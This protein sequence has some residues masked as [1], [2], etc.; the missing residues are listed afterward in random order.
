MPVNNLIQ[1]RR[2]GFSTWSSQDTILASGEPG[3]DLTNNILKIG[4][5]VTSWLNLLST[6]SADIYTYVKNTTG[7]AL[8]KGQV[9]YI[10]GAQG[11]NPTIQ[12]S[13]ASNEAGSS[14]TLGLLKQNLADNEFGY[15][16]SEGILE[17]IDTDSASA[18]GDSMWLSPNVSGGIVYGLANKPSAPNHM[19]FLGYVLRKQSNNGKIY[20][21]VQNG[22]ELEELHNVAI[23]G[24]S[25]GQFLQYNSGSG[26]WVGSSSGNFTTLSINGTPV[27]IS[28]HSHVSTDISDWNEAVDN[29]VSSLLVGTSGINISYNDSSNT[30]SIAYTGSTGGGGG[31]TNVNN[32]TDNRIITSDG[33]STGLNAESNLTF[34]GSKITI[35][36][37]IDNT[38]NLYSS[39]SGIILGNK[40][41]I[42]QS[43]QIV[44][45]QGNFSNDGDAQ[46]S[47][48]LLKNSTNS[49]NWTP[50]LLNNTNAILLKDNSTYS[51]DIYC[52]GRSIITSNN[53]AFK[54]QGLLYNDASG[55]AIV[56]TPIKTIFE[57]TEP[58]WDVRVLI[59]GTGYGTP[60]YLLTQV[61]G[62]TSDIYWVAKA[63]ML[64][65]QAAI[66]IPASPTTTS[67]VTPSI[68]QTKTVTP[69]F[70]PSITATRTATPTITPSIT[71]TITVTPTITPTITTTSTP[72]ITPT[73]TRTFTPTPSP[74]SIIGY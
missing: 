65:I 42:D 32:Y 23:S 63:D 24:V 27:S 26:L 30:L 5:G 33:T 14:K 54:L 17:G 20:I 56:G 15:V 13:I 22:Y 53:A 25:G 8:V 41:V 36:G 19:V 3:Y 31:G 18:A 66:Q 43:G 62:D 60:T 29:R 21:K 68:T 48:Y 49:S 1:L 74:T 58:S 11:N 2:G 47:Q 16:V 35:N 44:L 61:L 39:S 38:N 37:I 51:F 71:S 59:S 45:S 50:L 34:D 4:D 40:G 70:T 67:T 55:V 69:T 9:V 52:A 7:S 64:S 57:E 10:N 6:S 73:I 46:F 72:S 28:G 12:L